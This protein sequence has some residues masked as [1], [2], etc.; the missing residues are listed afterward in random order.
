[1]RKQ[2]ILLA[3]VLAAF[4]GS[5]AGSFHFDDFS[6]LTNPII[7]SPSGVWRIWAPIQTRP[8]TNLTFWLNYQF[9]GA[10]PL[11]FHVVNL[12]LHAASALML[13][14]VLRQ[15]ISPNAAWFAAAFFGLHPLQSEAVAYIFARA[16]LLSTLFSLLCVY[17]YLQNRRALSVMFFALA[18]LSKEDCV[19]LPFLLVL[20]SISLHRPSRDDLKP[21]SAIIGLALLAGA[22]AAW[23]TSVSAK[24]GAGFSAGIGAFAYCS[25]Q[26]AA[27]LRYLALLVIPWGFTI[28]P[29][30]TLSYPALYAVAWAAV[31]GLAML[32]WRKFSN[33]R[34]GFWFLS[35]L[36]LLIPSSSIFPASDLAADRRMYLP[37]IAFSAIFGLLAQRMP[38]W[39]PPPVLTALAVLSIFR[40][41]VWS[42]EESLWREAAGHSPHKV[43]PL[44]QLSRSV[45]G[46]QALDL[47]L[48]AER[49]DPKSAAVAAELGQLWL[50]TGRNDLALQEFGRALALAP[51]DANALNNRGAALLAL[52]Q[53]KAA[54]QDFRKAL[55][56]DPCLDAARRNLQALGE[57]NLPVCSMVK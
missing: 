33:L 47:L 1:M 2:L 12:A 37:M 16:T 8:F 35:G 3:S 25:V 54:A 30:L 19:T 57:T 15:L 11:G 17:Q 28:E 5:L 53:T 4:G 21:I 40:M 26:G 18:L 56:I 48:Q 36:V 44:I 29:N 20:L 46:N 9:G 43:R 51:R 34:W 41:T 6:L 52:K 13:F 14:L 24:S 10:N 7:T 45:P 38:V 50:K 23:A 22:R 32:A 31:A 55:Q 49:L 42:T 27:I 39:V